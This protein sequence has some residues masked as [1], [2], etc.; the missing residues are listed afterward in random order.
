MSKYPDD[1]DVY[2]YHV[3]QQ[4]N[5]KMYVNRKLQ[6]QISRYISKQHDIGTAKYHDVQLVV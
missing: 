5:I 3:I 6:E 4:T 1:S 2:E